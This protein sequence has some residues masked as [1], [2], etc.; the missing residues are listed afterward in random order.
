MGKE[1]TIMPSEEFDGGLQITAFKDFKDVGSLDY[2]VNPVTGIIELELITTYP[3]NDGTG[4]LLVQRFVKEV[5]PLRKIS[6]GITNV[7]TWQYFEEKDILKLV[8]ITGSL[9]IVTPSDIAQ[10]PIA[11]FLQ[12]GGIDVH[13]IKILKKNFGGEFKMSTTRDYERVKER[14]VA[15]GNDI[16]LFGNWFFNASLQGTT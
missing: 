2:V 15:Q 16:D 3:P 13:Q 11:H 6:A 4:L 5:G 8:T 12:K 1:F 10:V 9:D 7:R 14:W